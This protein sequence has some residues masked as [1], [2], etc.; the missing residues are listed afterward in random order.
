[1]DNQFDDFPEEMNMEFI[2]DFHEQNAGSRVVQ[3][4]MMLKDIKSAISHVTEH[5][6]SYGWDADLRDGLI[7]FLLEEQKAMQAQLMED[8][9]FA[10]T[11]IED[12]DAFGA[13]NPDPSK[14][15]V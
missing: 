4:I 15:G 14:R 9:H 6:I 1:M 10:S 3:D 5:G 11:G 13:L 2:E 12:G 7:D 8:Y